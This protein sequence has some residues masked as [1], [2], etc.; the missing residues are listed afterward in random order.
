MP[1][2]GV[3]F[4]S[5]Q[6]TPSTAIGERFAV[7]RPGGRILDAFGARDP[8][9]RAIRNTHREEI[10]VVDAISVGLPVGNEHDLFP[11][12]RP[13]NGVLVIRAL[14]EATNRA[15]L[16]AHHVDVPAAVIVHPRPRFVVVTSDDHRI[17]RRRLRARIR[18]QE[19]EPFA[20]GRPGQGVSRSL[21]SQRVVARRERRHG[22]PTSVRYFDHH[23]VRWAARLVDLSRSQGRAT[24]LQKGEPAP[25]GR[26]A[27]T[28]GVELRLAHRS[29]LAVR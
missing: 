27:R 11:R 26:P 4:S 6:R 18:G 14:G 3:R 13:G 22:L 21:I 10:V 23:H 2:L 5:G 15:V 19:S 20:V 17:A 28:I 24:A 7:E 12:R 25:V 8:A 9:Y 29:R 1:I 16:E